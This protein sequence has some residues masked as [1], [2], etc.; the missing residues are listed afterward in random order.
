[1]FVQPFC[2]PRPRYVP[3]PPPP[4]VAVVAANIEEAVDASLARLQTDYVDLLQIH[5]PDRYVPLFGEGCWQARRVLARLRARAK[6]Y[7]PCSLCAGGSLTL[8]R[9]AAMCECPAASRHLSP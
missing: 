1:M 3:L 7:R 6:W 5:W 8:R 9:A 4:P 2:Q